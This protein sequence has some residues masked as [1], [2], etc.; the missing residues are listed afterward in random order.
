MHQQPPSIGVG[1]GRVGR[2]LPST[3]AGKTREKVMSF[4][5]ITFDEIGLYSQWQLAQLTH[6]L[7]P[8][9]ENKI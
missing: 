4:S 7:G 2:R 8:R 5:G 1:E 3:A 9:P 6:T